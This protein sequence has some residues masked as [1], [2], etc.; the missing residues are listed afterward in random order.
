MKTN[1]YVD[2]NTVRRLHG[3]PEERRK[4]AEDYRRAKQHRE[5]VKAA[6]RNQE[7]ARHMNLSHVFFCTVA[8]ALVVAASI[9]YINIQTDVNRHLRTIASLESQVSDMK[10]DNDALERRIA[11]SVDIDTIRSKA[12]GE[13]GMHYATEGQI[14]V[15]SVSEGDYMNQYSD[16]E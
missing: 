9:M 10:A 14:K 4:R 5:N 16:L 12:L 7:N 3:E 15:F 8:T 1:Y 13:L 11:T 2:G 6:K